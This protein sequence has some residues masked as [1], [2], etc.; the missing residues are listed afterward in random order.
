MLQQALGRVRQRGAAHRRYQGNPEQRNRHFREGRP[1]HYLCGLQGHR[2]E[3]EREE[4]R[5]GWSSQRH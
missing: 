4:P 5:R 3:L 2:A 1:S